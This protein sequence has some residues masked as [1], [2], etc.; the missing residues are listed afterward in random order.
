MN[1]LVNKKVLSLVGTFAL[2]LAWIVFAPSCANEEDVIQSPNGQVDPDDPIDP[3]DGLE[4]SDIE[5]DKL[6]EYLVLK[7]AVKTD[8]SLPQAVDRGLKIDVQD[9]IYLI[10]GYP[11]GNRISFKH[12]PSQSMQGFNIHVAN[13]SYFFNVP[14]ESNTDYIT[15]KEG[16][17][18]SVLV[19]DLD[20][21]EDED[22][23][24]PFSVAITIQPHDGSGNPVDQFNRVVTI[25]DPNEPSGSCNSIMQPFQGLE[26]PPRWRWDFTIWEQNETIVKV[27]APNRKQ[28]INSQGV[29]CCNESGDSYYVNEHPSCGP[30]STGPGFT[31]VTLTREEINDYV[32]RIEEFMWIFDNG[33]FDY[34]GIEDKKNWDLFNTNF[35]TK[36]L[37]Y[38]FSFKNYGSPNDI[39][40]GTHDFTP[41][42][43]KINLNLTNWQG[44]Y[45][46]PQSADIVYTCHTLLLITEIEGFDVFTSRYEDYSTAEFFD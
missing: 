35:C 44:P 27:W 20:I 11:L 14:K 18:T 15:P 16:D 40:V 43:S 39:L 1:N 37:A 8:G 31:K 10:K 13:A 24:Y 45:R 26:T 41:G 3:D 30:N 23:N 38:N 2:I 32:Q 6:S 9:T 5:A 12:N 46:I 19:L 21:P 17:S 36:A 25:E 34:Q 42:A 29:G 7:D 22:V 28:T 33:V 4:D